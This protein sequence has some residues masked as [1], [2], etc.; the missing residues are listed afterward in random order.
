MVTETVEKKQLTRIFTQLHTLSQVVYHLSRHQRN[1][2]R[3]K[4]VISFTY[5]NRKNEM[6]MPN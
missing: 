1:Y 6:K 4:I 5:L 3:M 2:S